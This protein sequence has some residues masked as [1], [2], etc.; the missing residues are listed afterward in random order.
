MSTAYNA[1]NYFPPAP[2]LNIALAYPDESPIVG[3][4][5]ALVDTGADGTFIPM[6]YLE[7]LGVAGDYQVFVR[8]VFGPARQVYIYTV[9]LIINAYR[10]PAIEVIGDDEGME[11]I[12]GRNVL[13]RLTLLL[14]GPQAET[15]I[16]DHL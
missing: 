7:E 13:N 12:L 4:L 16:I 10:L 8:P 11:L 14:N 9:D 6:V 5:P 3:P 1:S 15:K 2:V